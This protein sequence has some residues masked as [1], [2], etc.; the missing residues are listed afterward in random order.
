MALVICHFA[1]DFSHF[2]DGVN[3]HPIL[4]VMLVFSHFAGGINLLPF[5]WWL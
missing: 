5:R 4:L 1:G 3:I 2:A